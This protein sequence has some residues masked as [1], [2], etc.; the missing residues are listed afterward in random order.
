M[1]FM[2]KRSFT[3]FQ[4]GLSYEQRIQQIKQMHLGK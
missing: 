4:K 2:M 3:N 1:R